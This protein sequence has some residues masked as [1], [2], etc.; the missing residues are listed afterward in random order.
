MCKCFD[1]LSLIK[2]LSLLNCNSKTASIEFT[3][4]CE[5]TA[6]TTIVTN[7]GQYCDCHMNSKGN[8][9]FIPRH[10]VL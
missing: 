4:V 8:M 9:T 2:A 5:P 1:E 3:A 10:Y 6:T 7:F